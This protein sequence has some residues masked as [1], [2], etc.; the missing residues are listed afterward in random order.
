MTSQAC[1]DRFLSQHHVELAGVSRNGR[2]IG[3]IALMEL[4]AKG[5]R[6]SVIHPVA[7]TIADTASLHALAALFRRGLNRQGDNRGPLSPG[8][9]RRSQDMTGRRRHPDRLGA[10]PG[11]QN[12]RPRP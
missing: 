4:T 6:N 5:Y 3:N 8:S 2:K 12:Y 9:I 1:I 10:G 11:R 7:E